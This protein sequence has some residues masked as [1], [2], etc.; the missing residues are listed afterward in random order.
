MYLYIIR[1]CVNTDVKLCTLLK[2]EN[3]IILVYI[4]STALLRLNKRSIYKSIHLSV[5][6]SLPFFCFYFTFLLFHYLFII[7]LYKFVYCLFKIFNF[8]ILDGWFM[9]YE[10]ILIFYCNMIEFYIKWS[11]L[12]ATNI[13][14]TS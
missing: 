13:V 9:F 11:T 12:R 6:L 3:C 4:C 5:S 2:L 14:T 10:S 7:L 8:V 1:Y